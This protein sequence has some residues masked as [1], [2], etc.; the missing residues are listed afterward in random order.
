MD[1]GRTSVWG[2]V[3]VM[4]AAGLACG[5]GETG[6]GAPGPGGFELIG[7]DQNGDLYRIDTGTGAAALLHDLPGDVTGGSMAYEPQSARLGVL[8]SA[9]EPGELIL[10]DPVAGV[11]EQR[12]QVSG[13]PADQLKTGGVGY[14]GGSGGFVVTFGPTGTTLE[15]KLAL[16]DT[17]GEVV[18]TSPVL[19]LGDNDGCFW[20]FVNERLIVHDYNAGDGLPPVAAMEDIFT[21]PIITAVASPPLNQTMGNS[22][23]H[24]ETGR[25]YITRFIGSS[26]E[27]VE[28]VGDTYVTVGPY[29]AASQI[30]GIAFVPAIVVCDADLTGDGELDFF[31]LSALLMGAVDYNGDTGFDFFD[32]SLYLQDY[33]AGCP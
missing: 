32:I 27:L 28:L 16:I 2:V 6:L 19:G 24:P 3:V 33:G 7:I 22:A 11:V 29:N 13:L 31:D 14:L 17:D 9:S 4:A 8:S 10:I 21:A 20:D 23:S 15:D 26:G 12:N 1:T 30:T 25:V 5:A 18:M